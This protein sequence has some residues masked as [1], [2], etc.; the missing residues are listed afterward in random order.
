RQTDINALNSHI[1]AFYAEHGW[2]P[3]LAQI[4]DATWRGTNMKGLDPDALLAPN[5]A[6]AID[7]AA[8]TTAKYQYK[9]TEDAAGTTACTATGTADDTACT[10]F[11]VDALLESSATTF[12]KS[13]N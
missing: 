3:T 13:S 5:S 4:T 8:S 11:T 1:Q 12:S 7:A 10:T 2:Y 6:T 9:P